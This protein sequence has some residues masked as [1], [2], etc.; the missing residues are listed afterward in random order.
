M[1]RRRRNDGWIWPAGQ[2]VGLFVLMGFIYPPFRQ[3][4]AGVGALFV[5]LLVLGVV[6]VLGLVAYRL[7][8]RR[9]T[10]Q[11]FAFGVSSPSSTLP[12]TDAS[13]AE[14][15]STTQQ[16]IDQMRSIDWSSSWSPSFTAS[17]AATSAGAAAR[18]PMAALIS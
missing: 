11:T 6:S 13:Q 14:M 16:L 9:G 10:D 1:A 18:T 8:A 4:V 5:I 3:V 15:P 2:I 12:A 17:R 7:F